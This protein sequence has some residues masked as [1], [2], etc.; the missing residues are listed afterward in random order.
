MYRK[1]GVSDCEE[2]AKDRVVHN[3][4]NQHSCKMSDCYNI[5]A[6]SS[7]FCTRCLVER[8]A[9]ICDCHE[10]Y[11]YMDGD[12]GKCWTLR[13]QKRTPPTD[14]KKRHAMAKMQPQPKQRR[15][16]AVI[17]IS[18]EADVK[19]RPPITMEEL[20]PRTSHLMREYA[21][22]FPVTGA[23]VPSM[24]EL[25]KVMC[26]HENC[27]KAMQGSSIYC[28]EHQEARDYFDEEAVELQKLADIAE[29]KKRLFAA[30]LPEDD[31]V[32]V[33]LFSHVQNAKT[34]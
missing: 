9:I 28:L 29:A 17:D 27:E 2:R 25:R 34:L 22:R 21:R 11:V 14:Q 3:Y 30:N 24:E 18:E 20:F 32:K 4:C 7:R 13:E 5:P 31:S 26:K 8:S 6:E 19:K 33:S 23:G 1:C 12:C 16:E 15:I 10:D